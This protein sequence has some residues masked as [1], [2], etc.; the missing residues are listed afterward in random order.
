VAAAGEQFEFN[1]LGPLEVRRNGEAL[2][3]GGVRQRSLLTMLLLH[4]NEVIPRERLIDALWGESPPAT[5]V[6]ALQVAVHGLRKLLGHDRLGSHYGGYELVVEPGELDLDEFERAADHARSGVATATELRR[7]LSLWRG[8]AATDS[9]PDGVR[10][11]LAR[12]DELRVFLLEERF[13]ADL[14]VGR[15]AALVEELEALLA[16]HPYRERLRGQL[17]SP[18][19]ARAARRKRSRLTRV[20]G[21]RWSTT[22]ASSRARSYGS[23]RRGSS[24]RTRISIRRQRRR[25]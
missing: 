7:A 22:S 13:E 19:I 1:V 2:A 3:L 12:L 8:V 14:V 11:E 9:Y 18:S 17:K 24:A 23:S 6:N 20:R 25:L 5:A 15:H 21:G 16:E 4:R 10:S